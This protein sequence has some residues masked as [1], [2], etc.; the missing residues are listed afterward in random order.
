MEINAQKVIDKLAAKVANLT[1]D[2]VIAEAQ[3]EA[4]QEQQSDHEPLEGEVIG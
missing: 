3:I 4:M 1:R 2:L